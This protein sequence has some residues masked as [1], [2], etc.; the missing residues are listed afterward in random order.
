MNIAY[1]KIAY[2]SYHLADDITTV[3]LLR[4][5]NLNFTIV[6]DG[7]DLVGNMESKQVTTGGGFTWND[8]QQSPTPGYMSA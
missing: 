6:D 5:D 3:M 8:D 7:D 2:T 4:T 1:S